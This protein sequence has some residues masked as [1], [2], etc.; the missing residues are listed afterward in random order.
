M[1][2]SPHRFAL[3]LIVFAIAGIV[4]GAYVTSTAV[5]A[6]LSQPGALPA[7]FPSLDA[8]VH[9]ALGMVVAALTLGLAIWTMLS[10]ARM[11]VRA[12]AWAAVVTL[13]VAAASGWPAA[14]LSPGLGVFHALLGHVFL[15]LIVVVA[16]ATSAG[17]NRAVEIAEG[18]SRPLL[19][20]F[21]IATPPVVLLQI[22]LGAAY[23]HDKASVLPHMAVAMG[24][25]FLALIVSSVVLQNFLKPAPLRI[26]A[27]TLIAIV[28]T[29]VCLGIGAF[30]MLLLNAAGSVYFILVTVGHV[31][32]GAAT[33]AASVVMAM[34][35][36]RSIPPRAA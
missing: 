36:R 33:L 10:P 5:A 35:I 18:P 27:G 3:V 32:V 7:V 6:R 19:R 4:S 12:T 21:A 13:A 8:G 22:A 24:V 11:W 17:W 20:P 29:Q 2:T 25:A 28:L 9:R 16:V 26:A 23:R 31:T 14:P 1:T 15:S 30:L 34:Q